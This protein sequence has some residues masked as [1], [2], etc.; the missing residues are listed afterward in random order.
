MILILMLVD[1]Y[2][3]ILLSDQHLVFVPP[4]SE[5]Q[6]MYDQYFSKLKQTHFS[7]RALAI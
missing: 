6:K 2:P 3:L 5:L 4:V 1:R 7:H